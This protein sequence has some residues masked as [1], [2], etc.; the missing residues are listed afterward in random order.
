MIL[1]LG[2]TISKRQEPQ[3]ARQMYETCKTDDREVTL[4]RCIGVSVE[5]DMQSVSMVL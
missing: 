5:A 4:H 1:T 3:L 2:L